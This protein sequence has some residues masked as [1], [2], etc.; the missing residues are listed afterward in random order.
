MALW[1]TGFGYAIVTGM[2]TGPERSVGKVT[3][4]DVA[5]HAGCSVMTVS[6][7]VNNKDDVSPETRDRVLKSIA[8]LG[9]RPNILARS[10]ITQK[11]FTVGLVVP[12]LGNPFF[13]DII[14]G[15]EEVAY[16]GGYTLLISNIDEKPEREKTALRRFEA[17]M[18]DGVI[19]CSSRLPDEVLTE[20]LKPFKAAAV[21][22][23]EAPAEVAGS[24]LNDDIYGAMRAVH[25]LL[26]R[27]HKRIGFL[28]GPPASRSS[29][30]RLEGYELALS[31]SG[32]GLV[33][34]YVEPTEPNEQGGML[35][36]PRLLQ[37][38]PELDAVLCYNDLVAIG[39]LQAAR[40]LGRKVPQGLALVGYD[41]IRMAALTTP[42]LSTLRVDRFGMGVAA[43]ELLLARMRGESP[44]P[45][46]LRPELVERESA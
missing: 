23:R 40:G 21:V 2:V 4:A 42:P 34:S 20:H 1:S 13:P 17:S 24:V 8:E 37:R 31:A 19:V 30:L 28:A 18:V 10:L 41:D 16:R 22:S 25:Y 11:S 6:R 12:D 35:G 27:G 38:H 7:V 45:V 46:V 33:S 3:V 5:R 9:Y 26:A 44:G 39:A 29:K 15:A 43:M 32:M 14:R 36:L